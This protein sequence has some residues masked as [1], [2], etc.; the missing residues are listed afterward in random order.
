[1]QGAEGSHYTLRSSPEY[2]ELVSYF[3]SVKSGDQYYGFW[4]GVDMWI[5][6]TDQCEL[7]I[8]S[9]LKGVEHKTMDLWCVDVY[10]NKWVHELK[11]VCDRVVECLIEVCALCM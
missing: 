2:Q 9:N 6:T 7:V 8:T 1:M 5:D 3:K 4:N 10:G 11:E